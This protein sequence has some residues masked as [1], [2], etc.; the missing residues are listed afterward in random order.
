MHR[1]QARQRNS[2]SYT[3]VLQMV[4][5]ASSTTH[6]PPMEKLSD[7]PRG[8]GCTAHACHE[9]EVRGFPRARARWRASYGTC[10]S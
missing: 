9:Q 4:N 7:G 3:I 1:T 10:N 5:L 8:R 2:K 6:G